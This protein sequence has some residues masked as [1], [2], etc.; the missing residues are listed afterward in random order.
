[1]GLALLREHSRLAD[2]RRHVQRIEAVLL[3]GV[4]GDL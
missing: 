2:Q 1:V 4:A 3:G